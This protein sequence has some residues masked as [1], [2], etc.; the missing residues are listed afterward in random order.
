MQ[1]NF[2]DGGVVQS[3]DIQCE[4]ELSVLYGIGTTTDNEPDRDTKVERTRFETSY[5][6]KLLSCYRWNGCP[7]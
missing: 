2:E 7:E 4:E 1:T 5:L 3:C 6:L